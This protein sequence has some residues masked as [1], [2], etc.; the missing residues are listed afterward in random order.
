MNEWLM[1]TLIISTK[2][3]ILLNTNAQYFSYLLLY[4]VQKPVFS[5]ISSRYMHI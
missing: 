3:S 2:V 5:H 4:F 1:A